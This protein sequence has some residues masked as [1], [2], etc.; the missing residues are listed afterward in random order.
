MEH[1]FDQGDSVKALMTDCGYSNVIT[2]KDFGGN[3]RV[4]VAIK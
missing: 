3:A 1:G 4:C 2:L